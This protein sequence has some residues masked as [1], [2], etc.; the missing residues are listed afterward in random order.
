MKKWKY[1]NAIDPSKEVVGV[2]YAA[3]IHEAYAIA[4]RMKD[5]PLHKFKDVFLIEQL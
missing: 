5:L 4:S 2:V 1:F 3:D